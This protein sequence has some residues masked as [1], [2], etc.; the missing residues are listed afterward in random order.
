MIQYRIDGIVKIVSVTTADEL[1]QA[2]AP[3]SEHFRDKK[4]YSW[5]FRGVMS[6]NYP[7]I[8]AV[9]RKGAMNRI[10]VTTPKDALDHVREECK[11][12]R[13]FYNLA[14]PRGLPLPEDS[15]RMRA[16][17]DA[18]PSYLPDGTKTTRWPPTELLSLC[19]LAQ[20]YGLPTRLLDW[21][22]DPLTAAY[23]AASGVMKWTQEKVRDLRK[24]I[25]QYCSFAGTPIN[26]TAAEHTVH[27]SIEKK[28]T[29]WAFSYSSYESMKIHE[30]YAL[31]STR[32]V[33]CEIVTMPYASN[34]NISAQQG[35][36]S[37]VR[38][39]MDKESMDRRPL[40]EIV[41]EYV[42]ALELGA[43]DTLWEKDPIFIRFELP[44]TE[45]QPLLVLLAKSGV[46]GST[47]FSDYG[48]AVE[49]VKEKLWWWE[50]WKESSK[51]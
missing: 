3:T 9:L 47:V 33:P 18:L 39:P 5:I 15:Q 31:N 28:M 44:W 34:P 13:A 38:H 11:V 22:H 49:A 24:V 12:M 10:N 20:H 35:L 41:A 8:P 27:G 37:V 48:G 25:R 7:L 42:A 26:E 40:D 51:T 36:F 17:M 45:F 29:V 32:P 4:P 30:K 16:L 21:T 43:P 6:S 46:N 19:G 50:D 14:D 2:L 23:F 1:L